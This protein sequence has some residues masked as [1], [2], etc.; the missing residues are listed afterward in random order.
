MSRQKAAYLIYPGDQHIDIDLTL[1]LNELKTLHRLLVNRYNDDLLEGV[2]T[3]TV[4]DLADRL[5]GV[6]KYLEMEHHKP[7][8]DDPT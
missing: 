8:Q 1:N 5:D 6:I 4:E 2:T 7:K 3:H